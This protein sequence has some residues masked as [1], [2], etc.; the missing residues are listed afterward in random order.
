VR[1]RVVPELCDERMAFEHGLHDAALDAAAAAV[2]EPQT[3]QAFVVRGDDVFLDDRRNISGSEGV[4]IELG[5]D[6]E[7]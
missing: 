2:D 4:E 6:R 7:R 5:A 1:I 3:A